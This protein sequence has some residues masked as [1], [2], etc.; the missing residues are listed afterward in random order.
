MPSLK[1]DNSAPA[2]VWRGRTNNGS[3]SINEMRNVNE[4][5]GSFRTNTSINYMLPT[6][7]GARKGIPDN[8]TVDVGYLQPQQLNPYATAKSPFYSNKKG[9]RSLQSIY[10]NSYGNSNVNELASMGGSPL[11]I[12]LDID[13]FPARMQYEKMRT[14]SNNPLSQSFAIKAAQEQDRDPIKGPLT[15]IMRYGVAA[16]FESQAVAKSRFNQGYVQTGLMNED[17]R[18]KILR[19]IKDDRDVFSQDVNDFK[20]LFLKQVGNLG[21]EKGKNVQEQLETISKKLD[22]WSMPANVDSDTSEKKKSTMITLEKTNMDNTEDNIDNLEEY[23]DTQ[24]TI[25]KETKSIPL[26]DPL[27]PPTPWSFTML[28]PLNWVGRN[29]NTQVPGNINPEMM[30]TLPDQTLGPFS[31]PMRKRSVTPSR[32]RTVSTPARDQSRGNV[33]TW[34]PPDQRD[35]ASI[36]ARRGTTPARATSRGN[37]LTW[38]PPDQRDTPILAKTGT[39]QKEIKKKKSTSVTQE[40]Y[41]SPSLSPQNQRVTR[42][43]RAAID[44]KKAEMTKKAEGAKGRR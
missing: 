39:T 26:P 14:D 43:M 6:E 10:P 4:I 17:K 19:Q 24:D 18:R 29:P 28:N 42:S 36:L 30:A 3:F 33:L 25:L 32:A 34:T 38:T 12:A 21:D 35:T 11:A 20:D 13:E 40:N 37:V 44:A 8:Q 9:K 15:D 16:D 22:N 1:D 23:Y 31:S 27:Q 7:L 41:S 2:I 5:Q